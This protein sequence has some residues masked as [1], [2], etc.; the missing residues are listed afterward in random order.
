M[1]TTVRA[2]LHKLAG[3]PILVDPDWDAVADNA[4]PFRLCCDA[5]INGFGATLEQEQPDGSVR[6]I[7]FVR[8]ATLDSERSWAPLELE[9]GSIVCAIKRLHGHLWSTRFQIYS[10]HKALENIAKVGEHNA[11]TR[12]WLE[13]LS[14]YTY[15]LEYR[16]GKANSNADFLSRLP[17]PATD[18]DRTRRNRLTGLDTVGIHR[19][20]HET[21][22]LRSDMFVWVVPAATVTS[23]R[24]LRISSQAIL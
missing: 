22:P 21:A 4:H 24:G 6:P 10:D 7:L 20:H 14:A 11:R 16:E 15:T 5:S 18:A 23:C 3:P 12:R 2:I 8:R 19:W 13:F 17:Q 1:E 9:D